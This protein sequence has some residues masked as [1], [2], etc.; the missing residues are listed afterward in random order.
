MSPL[1]RHRSRRCPVPAVDAASIAA[2]VARIAAVMPPTP[3]LPA[4]G[5]GAFLKLENL[6]VTGAYKVR[7][8]FN[9]VAAGIARGDRRDLVCASAG[10]HGLGVAW[11]AR[12]FDRRATVV[13]PAGAAAAKVGG[14][15]A[16][17]AEVITG[18]ADVEACLRA[19]RA[20][21]ETRGARLLHPFDDP[22]V[23]AG[24]A[25]V[26]VELLPFRPDV[27][28]VPIGG[29]G[30]AAGVC[31]VL[32]P[33]GVRVV[34][35]QVSGLDRFRRAWRSP[36]PSPLSSSSSFSAALPPSLADG[37][38]VAQPGALALSLCAGLLDDVVLVAED[39]IAETV[40]SL[41]MREKV[42]AEGAGA[43]AVAALPLVSGARKVAIV[44]GGNIDAAVL[45][46]LA[47]R[48]A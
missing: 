25:T 26:A 6:Q 40:A 17:G 28:L 45:A 19:A 9:A 7:G 3:L 42:V 33:H 18:G 15:R 10:N 5:R 24:Q 37:L 31:V 35:V 4:P 23:I 16:L 47:A 32:K 27:V 43:A 41:A 36:P 2:A 20:L 21:A 8:A 44:S 13:V 30:L 22:D 11:A 29:G 48:A 46:R 39:Q 34:G 12:H 1:A 14:C 38:R